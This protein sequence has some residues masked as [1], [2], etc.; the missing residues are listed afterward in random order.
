MNFTTKPESN[1]TGIRRNVARLSAIVL[2]NHL[3]LSLP[4]GYNTTP[5]YG[6]NTNSN[7]NKLK[8]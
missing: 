8:F 6:I 7:P 2:T 5:I 1:V 4:K 3:L